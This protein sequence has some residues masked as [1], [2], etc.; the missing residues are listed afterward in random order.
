MSSY[1]RFHTP[2]RTAND[3]P[4]W[5]GGLD[6]QDS[7]TRMSGA[8]PHDR[9]PVRRAGGSWL[10]ID[11]SRIRQA[12]GAEVEVLL[13]LGRVSCDERIHDRPLGQD[14]EEAFDH[15]PTMAL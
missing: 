13:Q 5:P 7:S 14:R 8:R 9:L 15:F 2:V 1:P 12:Q 3:T 4:P 10:L 6:R 11:R